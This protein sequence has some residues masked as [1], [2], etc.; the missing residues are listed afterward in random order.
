MR[1]LQADYLHEQGTGVMNEDSVLVNGTLFGVFDGATSLDKRTFSD[2][3]T[4]GYLASTIA[5]EVFSRNDAPLFELT[6][7]ANTAILT[8]MVAEGVDV[9]KKEN[10]WSTS[11]AVGRVKNGRFDWVQ[12]GDS[13]ILVIYEDHTHELLVRHYDHDVETLTLW[14]ETAAERP[15]TILEELNAQIRK[16]RAGMNITYGVLNGEEE[17][18][19]FLNHGSVAL[20]GVKHI[21]LFTDG[22]FIPRED[23]EAAN[24]FETWVSLF[25]DKGLQGVRDHVRSLEQTDPGCRRFP[26]FKTHDDI[27]AIALSFQPPGLAA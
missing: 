13:L 8:E 18:L 24:D 3:V 1:A 10:L 12:S 17:A 2:G 26:R 15:G 27:A 7:K 14:K 20:D 9:S 6:Q 11:M 22:L 4:G 16:V 21:L 23:P 25:L 5:G 19:S